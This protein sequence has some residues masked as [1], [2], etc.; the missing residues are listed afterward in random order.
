MADG[1]GTELKAS[2]A[3]EWSRLPVLGGESKWSWVVVV[4]VEAANIASTC[5]WLANPA[6][7][8]CPPAGPGDHGGSAGE[9]PTMPPVRTGWCVDWRTSEGEGEGD[10]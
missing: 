1:G 5:S 2:A 4:A 3:D 6:A 10:D 7:N 8:S 9:P